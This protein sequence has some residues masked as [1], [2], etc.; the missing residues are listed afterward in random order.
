MN[1]TDQRPYFVALARIKGI[2]PVRLRVIQSFFPSASDAWRADQG[3]LQSTGLDSKSV[4]AIL[5]ARKDF[6][7]EREYARVIESKIDILTWDDLAYPKLLKQ[8]ADPPPVLYVRGALKEEDAWAISIVGTRRVTSYGRTVSETLA[9]E[10]AGNHITVVSGLARGIDGIAHQAA[11]KAGGRTIAVLGC[12]VDIVYPSEH[13]KLSHEIVEHGALVSDYPPGT[14]P[15]SANFPP[16][17]RIIS[18][19]S[20]GVVVVEAGEPS[21]ALITSDFAAEQGREVFAV[22]GSILSHASKGTNKL[23]QKGAKL[24]TC[25]ADILEELNISMVTD[26]ITTQEVAPEDDT[27]KAVLAQL[28]HE[29]TLTDDLVNQLN[30]PTEMVTST[31]AI[32]ELKGMVRQA[33]GTS[34]VLARE[35]RTPYV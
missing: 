35:D 22:P 26:Y 4:H 16:R 13:R 27:E 3:D 34:Y 20:L 8:I 30:M 28:S 7:P 1:P 6:D 14:Q 33:N 2:G 12:G 17:N 11:I 21:G 5:E 9:G 18:G 19:L 10:L 24:V 31:L 15:E 25:V 29:P 23:I 32:M